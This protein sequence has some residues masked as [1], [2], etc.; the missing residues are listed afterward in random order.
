MKKL[1]HSDALSFLRSVHMHELNVKPTEFPWC[2][3]TLVDRTRDMSAHTSDPNEEWWVMRYNV[4]VVTG[5]GGGASDRVQAKMD[6]LDRVEDAFMAT[7]SSGQMLNSNY[8]TDILSENAD[9]R[10][11]IFDT[12]VGAGEARDPRSLIQGGEFTLF[13][14]VHFKRDGIP[15]AS[16]MTNLA[17]SDS[18]GVVEVT[19]DYTMISTDFIVKA[20]AENGPITVRLPSAVGKQTRGYIVQKTDASE[21]VVSVVPNGSQKISGESSWPLSGPKQVVTAV[22]DGADYIAT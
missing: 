13:L 10:D 12:T 9:Y 17:G 21:N 8:V 1:L 16:L 14:Q 18:A 2:L 3:V 20:N 15:P 11:I 22:S 7:R 5:G 6:A 19:S 4:L